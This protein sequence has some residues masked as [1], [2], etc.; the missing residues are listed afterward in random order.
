[1]GQS[2][3]AHRAGRTAALRAVGA[4][5]RGALARPLAS[6]LILLLFLGAV[7]P[8]DA[9]ALRSNANPIT[10]LASGPE[11]TPRNLDR[12][13]L[14]LSET[15][16]KDG[17]EA[18]EPSGLWG[19][20][21]RNPVIAKVAGVIEWILA[22]LKLLW[23]IPKAIV[24]GDSR[25]LIEAIGDLISRA[26]PEAAS[27]E[28][29]PASTP[30]PTLK[31]ESG[32]IPGGHWNANPGEAGGPSPDRTGDEARTDGPEAE[33]PGRASRAARPGGAPAEGPAGR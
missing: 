28:D 14:A 13:G 4:P 15:A 12:K 1:M 27:Q 6:F 8:P 18:S 29:P 20:L 19:K 3:R 16:G 32:A 30:P 11:S 7:L 9:I 10:L 26:T 22:G 2:P 24:Q 21:R 23:A 25:A 17:G 33:S 31:N 5:D